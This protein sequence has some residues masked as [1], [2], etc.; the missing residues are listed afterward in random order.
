MLTRRRAAALLAGALA[1]PVPRPARAQ[2]AAKLQVA[3]VP[4]EAA[5]EAWYG[6]DA[7]FFA[8]AGLDVDVQALQSGTAITPAVAS[9]AIDVGFVAVDVLANA[10]S[11]GLPF[12]AIAPAAEYLAP[13]TT[14]IY[15][16]VLPAGSPIRRAADLNGKVLAVDTLRGIQETA[17]RVWI[18]QHGGDSSTLRY[19]E[20]PNPAKVAALDTGR[21]DAVYITE[22]FLSAVSTTHRVLAYGMDGI[23]KDFIFAVWFTT[24]QW[25]AAHP[26]LAARFAAAI[27][28]T[29]AWANANPA[30]S[31]TI[32]AKYTHLDPAVIAR[33]TRIRFGERLNA[34]L[35]EPMIR[36]SAKYDGFAPFPAQALL[37]AQR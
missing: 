7:G 16:I 27:R 4:V 30:Q 29:A 12:V 13:E 15:G 23:A 8:K 20:I 34:P 32:L 25:A 14:K 10:F 26:D 37:S 22:P 9:G 11:K 19:I 36:V 24:R 6:K 3:V 33:M 17:A 35:L 21:A 31:G 1:A 5:A 2:T 28:E 18:D